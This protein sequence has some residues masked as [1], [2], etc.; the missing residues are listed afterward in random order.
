M[1]EKTVKQYKAST[2]KNNEYNGR[3]YGV[4]FEDGKAFFSD[5]T[6]KPEIGLTADE[7]A[8]RMQKDLGYTVEL[9]GGAK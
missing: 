9:V 4:H 6:V 2:P 8:E 5:L 7:I 1:A 3:A